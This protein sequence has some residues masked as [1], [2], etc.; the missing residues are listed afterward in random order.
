MHLDGAHTHG[1]GGAGPT[2]FVAVGLFFV[3]AAIVYAVGPIIQAAISLA[4]M[5]AIA[6]AC[7]LGL[8]VITGLVMFL[9]KAN[10]RQNLAIQAQLTEP[11]PLARPQAVPGR[12]TPMAITGPAQVHNHVHLSGLSPEAAEALGKAISRGT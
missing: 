4:E 3:A 1:G 11:L 5:L 8:A 9:V 7:L 10:R 6:A 12:P 2:P